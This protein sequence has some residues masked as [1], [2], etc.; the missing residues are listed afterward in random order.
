M[1]NAGDILQRV[2]VEF[3]ILSTALSILIKA[4]GEKDYGHPSQVFSR[5]RLAL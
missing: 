1:A 4:K 2:E 5:K 3:A